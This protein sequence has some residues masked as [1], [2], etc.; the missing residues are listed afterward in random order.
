MF[1]FKEGYNNQENTIRNEIEENALDSYNSLMSVEGQC[2]PELLIASSWFHLFC[3]THQR[4]SW[5]FISITFP[6]P[7]ALISFL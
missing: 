5:Y 7:A 2:S 6:I 4:Q 3:C 1:T